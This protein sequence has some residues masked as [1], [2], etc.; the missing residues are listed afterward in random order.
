MHRRSATSGAVQGMCWRCTAYRPPAATLTATNRDVDHNPTAITDQLAAEVPLG[1]VGSRLQPSLW[2]VV[3]CAWRESADAHSADARQC[4]AKRSRPT[5]DFQPLAIASRLPV[6]SV[7]NQSRT[8]ALT[9]ASLGMRR[10]ARVL[11][12]VSGGCRAGA[13]ARLR[14]LMRT[15]AGQLRDGRSA[16]SCAGTATPWDSASSKLTVTV[17]NSLYC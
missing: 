9:P 12:L 14:S 7:P 1:V 4:R 5:I 13:S 8:S 15:M 10:S 2:R 17:S 6:F 11:G 16:V 3:L